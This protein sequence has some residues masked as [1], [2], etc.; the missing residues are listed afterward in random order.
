MD[1][2]RKCRMLAEQ[3]C[4]ALDGRPAGRDRYKARCPA[5]DDKSPSLSITQKPDRVLIHCFSGCSQKEVIS[6]LIDR[7]LWNQKPRKS[8]TYSEADLDESMFFCVIWN[9]H[10]RQGK[11]VSPEDDKKMNKHLQ[12]LKTYSR[13]RFDFVVRD[14]CGC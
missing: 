9:S 2:S 6:A 11:Y 7:G 8:F 12:R 14:A 4:A 5:H 1:S 13:W 3:L 10:I